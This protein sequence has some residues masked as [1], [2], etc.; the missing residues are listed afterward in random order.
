MLL[1]ITL[2]QGK[3]Y[4]KLLKVTLSQGKPYFKLLKISFSHG[5][6]SLQGLECLQPAN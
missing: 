4:F 3:P 2:S 5:S 1:N 6:G